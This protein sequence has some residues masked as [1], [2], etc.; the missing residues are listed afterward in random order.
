MLQFILVLVYGLTVQAIEI[1]STRCQTGEFK[2]VAD[3]VT[4]INSQI[5]YTNLKYCVDGQEFRVL[6]SRLGD[7]GGDSRSG[8]LYSISYVDGLCPALNQKYVGA[9]FSLLGD[10]KPET[11]AVFEHNGKFK[12]TAV[13]YSEDSRAGDMEVYAVQNLTCE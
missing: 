11:L 3:S 9:D 4:V 7:N 6:A 13:Y 2:F 1:N 5:V 10:L 12:N 8:S